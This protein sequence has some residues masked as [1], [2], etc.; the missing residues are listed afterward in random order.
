MIKCI[1]KLLFAS[2][3]SARNFLPSLVE[4]SAETIYLSLI[5]S[6]TL[7][8]FIFLDSQL[9]VFDSNDLN[10]NLFI[11]SRFSWINADYFG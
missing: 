11:K 9:I 10:F 5:S 6:N 8:L 3:A 7:A 4:R 2:L 1:A